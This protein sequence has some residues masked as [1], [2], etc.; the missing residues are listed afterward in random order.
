MKDLWIGALVLLCFTGVARAESW[1]EVRWDGCFDGDTCRFTLTDV[2]PLLGERLPVD[3]RG[4]DAPELRGAELEAGRSARDFLRGLLTRSRRI[5]LLNVRQE[6]GRLTADLCTDGRDA[7]SMLVEEGHGIATGPEGPGSG[8]DCPAV[9]PEWRSWLI[10]GIV[11]AL[12]LA[13]YWP[14][15]AVWLLR[16]EKNRLLAEVARLP[17]LPLHDHQRE[18]QEREGESFARVYEELYQ[19]IKRERRPGVPGMIYPIPGLAMARAIADILKQKG[20]RVRIER[21]GYT[22]LVVLW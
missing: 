7:A 2:P 17:E 21:N 14:L 22:T 6:G 10:T 11:L 16:S 1:E 19:R 15:R 18:E 13:A 3:I 9:V 8:P 4:V 12:A 20:Y 5:D